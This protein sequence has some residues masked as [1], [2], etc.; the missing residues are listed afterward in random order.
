MKDETSIRSARAEMEE[1]KAR[2]EKA[3]SEA[4]RGPR[5]YRMYDKIKD[6]VSL[7]AVDAVIILVAAAIVIL[8]VVGILTG[9]PPQ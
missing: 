9:N 6:H 7:K 4:P 1:A 2:S 5:R 3:V 8:L